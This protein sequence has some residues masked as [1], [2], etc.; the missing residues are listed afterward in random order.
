[1]KSV[2][3]KL[4]YAFAGFLLLSV[5]AASGAV[6]QALETCSKDPFVLKNAVASGTVSAFCRGVLSADEGKRALAEL[7]LKAIIQSRPHSKEAYRAHSTLLSLYFRNGLYGQAERQLEQMLA[8]EPTRQDTQAIRSLLS[9]LSKVPDPVVFVRKSSS[10]QTYH[11]DGNLHIPITI[12]GKLARY[13]VDTGANISLMSESEAKRLGLEV[14]NSSSRLT[15]ISGA[16]TSAVRVTDVKDLAIGETHIRNVAFV[17]IP[18]SQEPFVDLPE[19]QRGILGIPVLLALGSFRMNTDGTMTI[20]PPTKKTAADRVPLA[21]VGLNPVTRMIFHGK[22][23]T[24]TLDTGA[25]STTLNP[26]FAKLFP[27]VVTAG[28]IKDHKLTGLGG[29]KQERSSVVPSLTFD[30]GRPV[31]LRP[32]T[33][34]LSDGKISQVWAAGNLGF[35]LM[36]Q[37]LPMTIDFTHMQV[38]F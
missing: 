19:G 13:I 30:F 34:F 5:A 8:E 23:L 20:A 24:F 28:K 11:A 9:A 12:N 15:G 3:A 22:S 2:T 14:W 18:D 16:R 25:I 26:K 6:A 10:V 35:D 31:K 1:M 29:S 37:A 7:D 27:A 21:F 36:Q 33:I 38:E 4:K 32:A 17:V